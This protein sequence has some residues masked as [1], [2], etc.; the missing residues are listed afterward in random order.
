LSLKKP[1]SRTSPY[2][3]LASITA[4][5]TQNI[6]SITFFILKNTSSLLRPD[7]HPLFSTL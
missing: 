2:A 3:A 6:L 4:A 5:T 1:G 7:N